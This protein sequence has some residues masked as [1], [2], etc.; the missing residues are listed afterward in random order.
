MKKLF[1]LRFLIILIASFVIFEAVEHLLEH[2]VGLDLANFLSLGGVGV[3]IFA[4]FKF[5]IICCAIPALCATVYCTYKNNKYC[6]CNKEH[7]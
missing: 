3:V 2:L 7:Q 1:T 5:H 4:G 6:Q